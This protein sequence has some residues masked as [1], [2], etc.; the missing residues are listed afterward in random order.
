MKVEEKL[1][2]YWAINESVIKILVGA[3][4]LFDNSRG[5]VKKE[6]EYDIRKGEHY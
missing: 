5:S 2:A 6:F 4:L 3:I 1:I